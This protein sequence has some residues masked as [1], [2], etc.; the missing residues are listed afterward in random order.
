MTDTTRVLRKFGGF[1]FRVENDVEQPLLGAL[2]AEGEAERT[3]E[4]VFVSD[5]RVASFAPWELKQLGLPPAAPFRI[6]VRGEGAIATPGFRLRVGLMQP[7][8]RPVTGGK[9]DGAV[10][11]AGSREYV[12]LNPL[13]EVLEKA[14]RFSSATTMDERMSKWC[15]LRELL[16]EGS[17]VDRQLQTINLVRGDAFTLDV[18]PGADFSPVLLTMASPS[19]PFNDEESAQPIEALPEA[20]QQT[21]S[22]RFEKSQ[23]VNGHYALGGG[24]YV[25]LPEE[26]RSAL[27]VVRE[28]KQGS[29]NERQAFIANPHAVLKNRLKGCVD[30][31]VVEALFSEQEQFLSSRIKCLG[32]W[33]PKLCAYVPSK[34]M[35]WIPEDV[36]AFA[37][38]QLVGISV[39]NRYYNVAI[40]DAPKVIADMEHA[41]AEGRDSVDY[42]GQSIPVTVEAQDALLRLTEQRSRGSRHEPGT[43]DGQPVSEDLVPVLIDNL[44]ELGFT[45][46]KRT[47]AIS[48]GG[49]PSSL[50]TTSL[51]PHQEKGI[52][53]LQSSWAEGM[54][55]VLLADDMGLGKTLQV[56]TFL[57][58]LKEQM[59]AGA[60]K[61]KPFLIVAPTGLLRNWEKEEQTH[62]LPPGLGTLIRAYGKDLKSLES[63]GSYHRT[64]TL[65]EADW[66][67]TTYETLRDRIHNFL[68]VDWAVVAFDEAQKIKNPA[69][70]MTDMAKSLKADFTV[71]ITGTPVENSLQDLWSIMDAAHPGLLGALKSFREIYQKPTE[72]KGEIERARELRRVLEE[73]V[74]PPAI[75]RR[76]KDDHLKGLPIRQEHVIREAMPDL[77][78]DAYSN[79]MNIGAQNRGRAGGMLE[80]IQ[81]L[82]KVSLLA[83]DVSEQGLSDELVESSA[84]L[85][86][87]MR[88]LETIMS[89]GEKALI[90][91][92]FINLQEALIPYLTERFR[93]ETPPL[94]INGKISSQARQKMVDDFQTRLANRFDIMLVSPK[95][96][97]VGL[98]LT[99]ANHVIH[100][101][102]W[103]NPAVE[104]QCTD[105]VYRI[106]QA[107]DEVHV[108]YPLAIHPDAGEHSFDLNLHT[109]L[110][111]KRELSHNVLASPEVTKEELNDL[112]CRSFGEN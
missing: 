87:T 27:E 79:A 37:G 64:Q 7:D 2:V 56:L 48:P 17:V 106:G 62:L 72:E 102:R 38:K 71:A 13:Y 107:H 110:T 34:D 112:F 43:R 95:A 41:E 50:K 90:F 14:D 84:R 22:D 85:S 39:D 30:E 63:Q 80:A 4:G 93:L 12:L 98:T 104:D 53:W 6:Q 109:L 25:T 65:R 15:D 99:A 101:S 28:I 45:A 44:E 11:R 8:G 33:Q 54:P 24:W 51:Y 59:E 82:R 49:L 76:M 52:H 73:Q 86:A 75:L 111:R 1:L 40:E 77:Q 88:I 31:E 60:Q 69:S 16:P 57:G 21:F 83:G 58:W 61:E 70:R 46:N 92:E 35:E 97:G 96:G 9:R 81:G 74:S 18:K 103:W 42:A 68:P 29:L 67:M 5:E 108:Y 55:G 19:K 105:R 78:A 32:V 89:R 94:R 47:T 91:M 23:R 100:L 36:T 10:F 20:S 66:V 3:A 26:T